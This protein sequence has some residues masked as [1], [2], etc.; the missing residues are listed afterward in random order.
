MVIFVTS[1]VFSGIVVSPSV[2]RSWSPILTWDNWIG[3]WK[4]DMFLPPWNPQVVWELGRGCRG[5]G[6][7]SQHIWRPLGC[8]HRT[9]QVGV[10][11]SDL[12]LAPPSRGICWPRKQL[13]FL[14]ILNNY[15]CNQPWR[16]Q[17]HWQSLILFPLHICNLPKRIS[18]YKQLS[19]LVPSFRSTHS[20]TQIFHLIEPNR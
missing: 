9:A 10:E 19:F 20:S 15:I 8:L 18:F 3:I 14:W 1:I 11:D 12:G 6:R 13:D 2:P 4:L 17:H 7:R 16:Q 5:S